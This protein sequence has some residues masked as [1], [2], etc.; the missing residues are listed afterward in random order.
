MGRLNSLNFQ[1]KRP[2][3]NIPDCP[4]EVG[5]LEVLPKACTNKR[6]KA[7]GGVLLI[8]KLAGGDAP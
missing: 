1:L 2:A 8:W 5:W 7:K 6:G 3:L 4:E